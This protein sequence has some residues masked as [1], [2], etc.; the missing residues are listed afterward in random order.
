MEKIVEKLSH[1]EDPRHSGHIKYKLADVS[2]ITYLLDHDRFLK[3]LEFLVT[4]QTP[5]KKHDEILGDFLGS[6]YS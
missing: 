3:L 6:S 5:A 1:I 4:V 2:C